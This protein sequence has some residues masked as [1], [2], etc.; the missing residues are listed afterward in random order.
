MEV[1]ANGDI[2]IFNLENCIHLFKSMLSGNIKEEDVISN[3][4]VRKLSS[5]I[6]ETK[7]RP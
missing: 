6:H 1:D 3:G 2:T 5:L 7:E 4:N